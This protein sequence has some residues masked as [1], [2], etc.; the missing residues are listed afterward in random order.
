[1][2]IVMD[3]G[4]RASV[5]LPSAF[6]SPSPCLLACFPL[7]TRAGGWALWWPSVTFKPLPSGSFR[8]ALWR[9]WGGTQRGPSEHRE[10][11]K[12]VRT[13]AHPI[14]PLSTRTPLPPC[15]ASPPAQKSSVCQCGGGPIVR[16]P[17]AE[18]KGPLVVNNSAVHSD[19]NGGTSHCFEH[20]FRVGIGPL[21]RSPALTIHT[22]WATKSLNLLPH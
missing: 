2:P 16:G 20:L 7:E 13:E 11:K 10:R 8:G 9:R 12:G 5:S 17:A 19:H 1:M 14:N 18:E 6:L 15:P 22:R 3:N 21:R 4:A